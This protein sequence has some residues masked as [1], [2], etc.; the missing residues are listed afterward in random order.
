MKRKEH[1]EN[2][3]Y[4][5]QARLEKLDDLEK[6]IDYLAAHTARLKTEYE[7]ETKNIQATEAAKQEAIKAETTRQEQQIEEAKKQLN[8]LNDYIN[9]YQA[10]ST[11]WKNA[12]QAQKE[13]YDKNNTVIQEQENK[14]RSLD[15]KITSLDNK[16]TE[17]K[18]ALNE[19]NRLSFPIDK[20]Y[21]PI[22]QSRNIFEFLDTVSG[23]TEQ[24]REQLKKQIKID[25]YG[26]IKQLP[27]KVGELLFTEF[28]NLAD[29]NCELAKTKELR[30]S[31]SESRQNLE[32]KISKAANSQ[33]LD[34]INKNPEIK[35]EIYRQMEADIARDE[36]AFNKKREEQDKQQQQEKENPPR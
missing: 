22:A 1:I 32:N 5:E 21:H 15:N 9:R 35:N 30:E 26:D 27:P 3:K 7:L 24:E 4:R 16:I 25:R 13:K 36:K 10:A 34:Y 28:K 33:I 19:I 20:V 18:A 14:V 23:I 11:K 6:D 29:M 2:I 31:I 12:I 8:K 17:Q